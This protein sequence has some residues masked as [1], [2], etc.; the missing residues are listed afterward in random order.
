MITSSR[1]MVLAGGVVLALGAGGALLLQGALGGVDDEAVSAQ[2]AEPTAPPAFSTP[3]P[4]APRP[5]EVEPG[6]E[7]VVATDDPVTPPLGV[8]PVF[9]TFAG[10]E[11]SVDGVEVSGFVASVVEA[12]G[13]C[14]LLLTGEAESVQVSREAVPNASTTSC[15]ALVVP[16]TQLSSGTWSAVLSYSSST[17]N[18]SSDPVSIEVP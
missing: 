16:L 15:G 9:V 7:E 6:P 4:T 2:A 5:L 10:V 11:P 3:T 17:S 1:R 12:D 8:A 14:S 13:T 18:G